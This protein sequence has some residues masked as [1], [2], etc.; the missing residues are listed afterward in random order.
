MYCLL[1]WRRAGRVAALFAACLSASAAFAQPPYRPVRAF[2]G[3]DSGAGRFATPIAVATDNG[4]NVF[5]ADYTRHFIL[6]FHGGA[7]VAQFG[8]YGAMSGQLRYPR[9]VATDSAGNVFVADQGNQRIDK[10]DNNGAFLLCFGSYGPAPGQFRDPSGVAVDSFDNVYVADSTNNRIQIFDNSGS[11]IS[12]FGGVGVA[13]G[14]FSAPVGV[15]LDGAGNIFVADSDNYRIQ[16][17][18]GVGQYLT[19]FGTYGKDAGRFGIPTGVATDAG[20]NVYVADPDNNRI[21][22]FDNNGVFLGGIGA[23]YNGAGGSVGAAGTLS[24]QLRS[25]KGVAVDGQGN[26]WVADSGNARGQEFALAPASL[27]GV[28]AFDGLAAKAAAQNVTFTFRSNDGS[29]DIVQTLAVPA[30]GVYTLTGLFSK[31]GVLHIKPDKFLAVNVSVDLTGGNLSG[32]SATVEPCDA[33][34]DNSVDSTDFGIL[35]GAFNT[36]ASVPGSGYDEAA[37]FNGDGSVDSTDFGLLIGN[38]NMLGA[39]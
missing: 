23:G 26:V 12:L 13:A 25:P 7:G 2:G 35:I 39:P 31:A 17:F 38:F 19:Q 21:E 29:A 28:L 20:G 11:L 16:K 15:A 3:L 37:D 33:N 10:F 34:N 36:Q 6:K 5:F 4:G 1:S 32:Q 14:S 18:T 30:S 27:S 22:K 24:G 8:G 9:G